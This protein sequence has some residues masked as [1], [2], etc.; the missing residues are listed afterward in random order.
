MVVAKRSSRYVELVCF[1]LRLHGSPARVQGEVIIH[2][3][4]ASSDCDDGSQLM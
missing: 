3:Y 1:S 2:A 4:L